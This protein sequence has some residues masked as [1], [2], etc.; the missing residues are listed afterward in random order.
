MAEAEGVS[1]IGNGMGVAWGDLNSDGRLDLY[2]SNMSSTAGN[3]ILGRLNDELDPETH[4]LLMKLA[5]GNS[6][7]LAKE[8]GGFERRE[9]SAGG[10]GGSWA[11]SPVLCDLD[12]DGFLDVYL[13]NGFVTGDQPFD[14]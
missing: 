9:K 13:A 5:A 1:D 12:L 14:T 11:W 3:R 4:A 2:V 10:L 8:G 7:F 6:I